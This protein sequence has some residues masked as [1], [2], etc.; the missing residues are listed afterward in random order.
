MRDVFCSGTP[1]AIDSLSALQSRLN[2]LP[3]DTQPL[4]APD[5]AAPT[6]LGLTGDGLTHSVLLGHSV[7][8][9]VHAREFFG[10]WACA[11]WAAPRMAAG[12][13]ITFITGG[14]V[15]RPSLAS[16]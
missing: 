9:R 8:S 4:I 10:S 16:R 2:L 12:G 13:S 11:R 1:P 6:E 7:R 3:T 15:E 14:A 5:V